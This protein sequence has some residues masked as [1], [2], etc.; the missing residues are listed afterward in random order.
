MI[1]LVAVRIIGDSFRQLTAQAVDSDTSLESEKII[2]SQNQI[3][4]WHKMRTRVIGREM[5]L[6]MHILVDPDLSITEAHAVSERLE[7]KLHEQI[8]HPINITIHIEPLRF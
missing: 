3:R 2:A 8:V 1:I 7:K 5:F 6:D 4:K